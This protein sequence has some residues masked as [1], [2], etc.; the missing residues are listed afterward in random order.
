ML[1]GLAVLTTMAHFLVAAAHLTFHP[2]N[3]WPLLLLLG[4]APIGGIALA[5]QGRPRHGAILLAL[6]MAVGAFYT[7]YQ[8]FVATGDFLDGFWSA[9]MVQMLLAFELQGMALGLTLIVKPEVPRARDPAAS[10]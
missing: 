10:S 5:M 4:C 3:D 9:W 6:T 8:H 1:L 7:L 2:V